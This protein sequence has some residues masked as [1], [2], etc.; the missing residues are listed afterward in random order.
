MVDIKQQSNR[1]IMQSIVLALILY[2]GIYAVQINWHLQGVLTPLV[3]SM[4]YV[5]I[6]EISSALVWRWVAEKHRDMLSSFFTAVSGFRFLSALIV[7]AVW[8]LTTERQ[9][10]MT[11]FVIFLIYYMASLI[12][13]SIF[14][15]RVSNRL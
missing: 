15:S 7:M 2:F 3:V 11:F 4:L 10:M 12:H 6:L 1:Y 5:L 9:S 13:H 8:Y 14:F